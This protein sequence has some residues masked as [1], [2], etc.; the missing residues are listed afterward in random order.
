M[1]R[2]TVTR[3]VR[4][5]LADVF[6]AVAH[7]ESFAKI[8]PEIVDVEFLSEQKR[9]LGARFRETRM[10]GKREAA[11]VLEVTEYV[12]NDRVRME[13]D[14]GGTIWDTLVTTRELGDGE[15]ELAMDMESR[16][17]RFAA[18]LFTPLLGPMLRKA[19]AK[20][21]DAVKAHCEA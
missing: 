9:G 19:L 21:L 10:M 13:A 17:Y 11:T 16:P 20:D 3:R 2:T 14:A 18:K 1:G 15:V 12:E 6:D 7:I 8:V 4:A 5:P